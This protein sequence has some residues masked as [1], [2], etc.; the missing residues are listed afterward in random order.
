[1]EFRIDAGR[2]TSYRVQSKEILDNKGHFWTGVYDKNKGKIYLYKDSV[3]E[4]STNINEEFEYDTSS[5]WNMIGAVDFGSWQHFRGVIDEVR[6]WNTARTK[7]QIKRY[8]N[9]PLR[10]DEDNLVAYWKF[11]EDS[12]QI[13]KDLTKNHNDGQLNTWKGKTGYISPSVNPNVQIE[14]GEH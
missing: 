5:M 6:I 2:G 14:A 12:G 7:K 10:G 8:M 11:D 4:N 13:L 1:M 3:L 9:R